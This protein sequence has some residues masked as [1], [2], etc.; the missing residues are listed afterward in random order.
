M[1]KHKPDDETVQWKEAEIQ[2]YIST[3]L[4]Q[5]N[6][7]FRVGLEGIP[8]HPRVASK[9]IAQ[10]MAPGFPDIEIYLNDRLVF[11]ELKTVRGRLSDRQKEVHKRLSD[12]GYDVN[13]V[14][15]ATPH[16]AWLEVE[17]II[18]GR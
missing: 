17:E 5:S 14:K 2:A 7:L 10:G 8:L 13:V 3:K 6:Y 9:A 11:I 12:L 1:I 15:R 4:R 16:E 18:A